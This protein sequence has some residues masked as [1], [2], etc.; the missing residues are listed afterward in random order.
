MLE[1]LQLKKSELSILLTDDAQIKHLNRDYRHKD[2]A[3]D[4]LAFAMREGEHAELAGEMLGDVVI[5]LETAARQARAQGHSLREE[6]V[7]LLGHGVLH[8]LGWDHDT[9]A[10]DRAMR[11]ETERLCA[12]AGVPAPARP[13]VPADVPAPKV[14]AGRRNEPKRKAATSKAKVFSGRG[15][16]STRSKSTERPRRK[17]V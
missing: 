15:A 3:T 17:S 11:C 6:V 13:G 2:R 12:A 8:L 1:T 10:K 5:S 7:F 14:A 16:S 4:V 9:K